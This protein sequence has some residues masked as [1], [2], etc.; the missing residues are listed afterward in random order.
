MDNTA[1]RDGPG[2]YV[3]AGALLFAGPLLRVLYYTRYPLLSPEAL[4]LLLGFALLGAFAALL[5]ARL[6]RTLGG[7]GFAALLLFFIGFEVNLTTTTLA[8]TG[9]GCLAFALILWR[10]R[11]TIIVL[12][13]AA[14]GLA[15]LPNR[16]PPEHRVQEVAVADPAPE[17]GPIIHIV[18][19]EHL[20]IGGFRGIGD[21]VT[22]D[23]L[24]RRYL[25]RGFAVYPAAYSRW[26]VTRGSFASLL[27]LGTVIESSLLT[28]DRLG[29]PAP[30]ATNPYF[31]RLAGLHYRLN[32]YQSAN[33][34]FCSTPGIVV[35]TCIQ[36][37]PNSVGNISYLR[38]I[39]WRKRAGL[40]LKTHL[41]QSSHLR[42]L[43]PKDERR[44]SRLFASRAVE[45]FRAA[46]A[47][48][49]R[50]K[51]QRDVFFAH[52]LLP[53]DPYEV[54][55]ECI[56]HLER[57]LSEDRAPMPDSL[58]PIR[59]RYRGQVRCVHRMVTELVDRVD[60]VFGKDRTIIIV[61]GDHGSRQTHRCEKDPCRLPPA[62][63][64]TVGSYRPVDFA[65]EFSTLLAVRIPGS[66]GGVHREPVPIQDFLWAVIR[67]GF[68]TLPDSGWQHYI[69]LNESKRLTYALRPVD[70]LWAPQTP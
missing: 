24:T 56:T 5:T 53:H 22:A 41:L 54:D 57:R 4:V 66:P 2:A 19:D 61:Q 11:A 62:R 1:G 60:S 50:R 52:L 21:S 32:V 48:L 64:N 35:A 39:S 36:V 40:I 17:R 15:T 68:R 70:M 37:P 38:R 3:L 58:S 27:S 10:W 34:D 31:Q 33:L 12:A 47:E 65:A 6:G 14:F 49:V 8:A 28:R 44:L 46:G 20:G 16:S 30:L 26:N 18:L 45:T 51:S 69:Y 43:F 13:L 55:Q 42:R 59:A 25:E 23:D 67:S 29:A 7:I 63:L 9:A